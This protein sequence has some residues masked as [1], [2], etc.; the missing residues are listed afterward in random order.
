MEKG[1]ISVVLAVIFGI[2]SVVFL[3]TTVFY[4]RENKA[5]SN[6]LIFQE[7]QLDQYIY[8]SPSP[9]PKVYDK[10]VSGE[11]VCSLTKDDVCPQWC[12][13]GSDYDCC[14]NVGKT[15]IEGR[16]CY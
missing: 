10:D 6:E 12:A 7:Q 3:A 8:S 14:I 11:T 4:F 9:T 16:G 5:L 2:L 13:P 1:S 15:W